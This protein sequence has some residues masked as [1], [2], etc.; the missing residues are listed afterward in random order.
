MKLEN[1]KNA[2]DNIRKGSYV[3]EEHQRAIP[4]KK[5]FEDLKVEKYTR[6]IVR[7]GCDY[8]N[9]QEIKNKITSSEIKNSNLKYVENYENAIL[10]NE[11]KKTYLIKFTKSRSKKHKTIT[12]W[13]LNGVEVSK[14]FLISLKCLYSNDEKGSSYD[15]PV[16]NVNINDLIRLGNYS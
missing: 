13:L 5:G 7:I 12:K 15:S 11:N 3:V 9:L 16:Y 1:L 8:E 10:Y 4:L 6:A 14:E 2:I